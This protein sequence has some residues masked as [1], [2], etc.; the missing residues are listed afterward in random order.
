MANCSVRLDHARKMIIMSRTFA[1]KAEDPRSDA[2]AILKQLREDNFGYTVVRKEIKKNPHSEHYKGLTYDYMRTYINNHEP[3]ASRQTISDELEHKIEIS[4]C[5][6]IRYATIKKWF[7]AKYPEVVG[8][9]VEDESKSEEAKNDNVTKLPQPE[10]NEVE[11][12]K[13]ENF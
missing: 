12:D 13:A 1:K 2:Y 6:S 11:Y 4:K 7:L 8:F 3:E 10:Q 5:H 9:G